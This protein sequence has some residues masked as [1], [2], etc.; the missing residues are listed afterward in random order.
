MLERLERGWGSQVEEVSRG[1]RAQAWWTRWSAV[2]CGTLDRRR[3]CPSANC[4]TAL[5][6]HTSI[7]HRLSCCKNH[8]LLPAFKFR[9][10]RILLEILAP[11]HKMAAEVVA[12]VA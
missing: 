12:G 2:M 11:G 7:T 4:N 10:T 3:L 5:P 6:L 9:G 8:P 1:V